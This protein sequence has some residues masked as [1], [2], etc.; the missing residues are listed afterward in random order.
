LPASNN[1]P[2]RICWRFS[3]V[4]SEGPWSLAVLDFTQ[5]L[6]LLS[7][8]VKFESQTIKELFLQGQWPGK[9]HDLATLPNRAAR[10]RLE[11]IGL[12]DMTQIWKLRIGGAGRLWGFLE[13]NVFH[14]VWWDPNHEIWPSK[15]KHT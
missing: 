5:L 3:H 12:S 1:S 9:C 14:V 15:L 8:L 10:V 4:D 13:G 2:D 6:T 11:S 7:E